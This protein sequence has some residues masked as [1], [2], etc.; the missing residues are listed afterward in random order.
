[1]NIKVGVDRTIDYEELNTRI[2]QEIQDCVFNST[3]A[4]YRKIYKPPQHSTSIDMEY[5]RAESQIEILMNVNKY[6]IIKFQLSIF[7]GRMILYKSICC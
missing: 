5:S 3:I 2:V 1:M 6:K 4:T 7:D